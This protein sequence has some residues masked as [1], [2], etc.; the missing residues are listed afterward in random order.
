MKSTA[1][2]GTFGKRPLRQ[3]SRACS[4]R[5]GGSRPGAPDGAAT[6][7]PGRWPVPIFGRPAAARAGGGRPW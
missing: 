6:R 4:I 3:S 1:S 7:F 2:P 5:W